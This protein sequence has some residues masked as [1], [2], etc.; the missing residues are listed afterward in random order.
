M[1]IARSTAN[2]NV[3]IELERTERPNRDAEPLAAVLAE[4]ADMQA[5]S[6]LFTTYTAITKDGEDTAKDTDD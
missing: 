6:P 2:S 4:K 3:T 1:S 5:S